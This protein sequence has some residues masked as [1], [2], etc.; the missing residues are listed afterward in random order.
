MTDKNQGK[1][2]PFIDSVRRRFDRAAKTPVP[3]SNRE[4]APVVSIKSPQ[5]SG[6]AVMLQR[7]W[8][9]IENDKPLSRRDWKFLVELARQAYWSTRFRQRSVTTGPLIA[10]LGGLRALLRLRNA[11][12]PGQSFSTDNY[13]VE[14]L[15][16]LVDGL[17]RD[18][19]SGAWKHDPVNVITT[20]IENV[21]SVTH[22]K[23]SSSLLAQLFLGALIEEPE[24]DATRL[25]Q[26]LAPYTLAVFRL[27]ARCCALSDESHQNWA[28][29]VFLQE[30]PDRMYATTPCL[31]PIDFT[32]SDLRLA[33]YP[34]THSFT[35]VLSVH[36]DQLRIGFNFISLEHWSDVFLSGIES[37]ILIATDNGYILQDGAYQVDF[38]ADRA[39]QVKKLLQQ[40]TESESLQQDRER[41]FNYWGQV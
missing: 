4:R 18:A 29:T 6:N 21:G 8:L 3:D 19:R 40:Y 27:A 20:I 28:Q 39:S 32:S 9:K 13:Y 36:D 38:L 5:A 12:Y 41:M 7:I 11:T 37:E 34:E 17:K 26:A 30:N 22:F 1:T 10:V 15:S 24:L 33:V 35:G 2:N 31:H 23:G 14:Q 25:S 16:S